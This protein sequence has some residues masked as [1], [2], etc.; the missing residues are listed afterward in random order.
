MELAVRTSLM[1]PTRPSKRLRGP[2]QG[3]QNTQ[4]LNATIA[5][6]HITALTSLAAREKNPRA[7]RAIQARL[8]TLLE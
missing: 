6:L 8:V 3:E 2:P 4:D 1:G 5:C 7:N